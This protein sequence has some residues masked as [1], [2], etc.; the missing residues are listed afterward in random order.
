[1][2][3][4]K[5]LIVDDDEDDFLLTKDLLAEINQDYQLDWAPSFED[6]L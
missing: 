2:Q 3:T 5:L 6:G 4:V 1:M